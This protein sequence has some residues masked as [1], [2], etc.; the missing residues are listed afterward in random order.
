MQAHASTLVTVGIPALAVLVIALGMWAVRASAPAAL[1]RVL[2]S[3]LAWLLCFGGLAASGVLARFDLRPP[4]AAL[5]MAATLVAGVA[6]GRSR[7]VGAVAA[8]VPLWGLVLSQAFRLPL[9]LV[10]H[11]AALERVMPNALSFSGYNFDVV[12]GATAIP[13]ALALRAGA[14]RA[15]AFAWSVLGSA[16]LVVIAAIAIATSPM[17]AALGPNELNS[18][19]T[20][21]PF[22]YLPTVLVVFAIAGHFAVFRALR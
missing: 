7:L 3:T 4:P 12:T 18:W 20:Q 10:M 13:V 9:E 21:L 15:L 2:L 1:G 16:C 11:E 8:T 22:V 17:L 14:P 6:L 19:V 5:M